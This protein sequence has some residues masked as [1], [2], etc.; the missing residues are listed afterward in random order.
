MP[1][2]CFMDDLVDVWKLGEHPQGPGW[3]KT[4]LGSDTN[5]MQDE[6]EDPQTQSMRHN[7]LWT[8]QSA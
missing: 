2:Q 8:R 7:V 6:D 3:R 4:N 1:M 5:L